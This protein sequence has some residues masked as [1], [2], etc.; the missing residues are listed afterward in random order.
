[1][2]ARTIA[3]YRAVGVQP[4]ASD[5]ASFPGGA[6]MLEYKLIGDQSGITTVATDTVDIHVLPAYSG[7]LVTGASLKTIIAGTAS[8]TLDI[9]LTATDVTGL[10]A[11]ALDA[12][13]GTQLVKAATAGATNLEIIGASDAVIRVQINTGG[14][15]SGEWRLRIWGTAFDA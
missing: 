9:Q 4:A 15:G 6:F 12:T 10:T 14:L 5:R 2:T 13:A 7:V 11:W 8:S 1:M 3:Q